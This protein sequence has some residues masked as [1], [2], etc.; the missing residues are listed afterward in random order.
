M[1][2][3]LSSLSPGPELSARILAYL[4]ET[5][6]QAAKENVMQLA[7]AQQNVGRIKTA[8]EKAREAMNRNVISEADYMKDKRA[9][10]E[11][12]VGLGEQITKLEEL[13]PASIIPLARATLELS[14][15]CAEQYKS[16]NWEEKRQLLDSVCSNFLLDGKK[17][18]P[19][20][21]KPFQL[22][23]EMASCSNWLRD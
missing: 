19:E 8:I 5:T 23:A 14:N 2:R 1:V 20:W 9:Y 22:V 13:A 7:V 16:M 11:Q 10:D 3:L 12:L 21:R 6:P 17:L 15:C 18:I 4:E